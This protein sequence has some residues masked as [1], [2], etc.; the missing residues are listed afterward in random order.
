MGYNERLDRLAEI[1]KEF[2]DIDDYFIGS[3][4]VDVADE[5]WDKCLDSARRCAELLLDK[6]MREIREQ[7]VKVEVIS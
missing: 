3:L 4:S 2:R 6:R 1:R 5:T 7:P